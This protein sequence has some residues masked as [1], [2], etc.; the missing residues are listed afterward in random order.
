[1]KKI[2][3]ILLMFK[4]YRFKAENESKTHYNNLWVWQYWV[5]ETDENRINTAPNFF[6]PFP[7]Q[8]T[9]SKKEKLFQ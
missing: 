2:K 8:I 3:K 1:M 9:V 4:Y 6:L 5:K 7:S